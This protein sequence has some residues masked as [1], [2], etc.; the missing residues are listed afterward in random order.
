M[1]PRTDS[2]KKES[3]A[4]LLEDF[5]GGRCTAE[6]SVLEVLVTGFDGNR[7]SVA[8]GLKSDCEIPAEEFRDPNGEIKVKADDYVKVKIELLDDGRGRTRLSR[9]L[10]RRDQTWQN[11]LQCFASGEP[12]EGVIQERVKGGYSVHIDGLRCFLPGSLVDIFPLAEGQELIGSTERFLVERLKES[13]RSAILNRKILREREL[14]GNDMDC[15]TFAE[16][17]VVSGEVMA[18]AEYPENTAFVKIAE[19]VHG[20]LHRSDLSW[21]RVN[22][23]A[24]MIAV[25]DKF[26]VKVLKIDHEKKRI[27]VGVKDLHPDPYE[28]LE[29]R[30][31]KGTRLFGKV[32]AIKNYGAFVEIEK[33][34]EGLVHISEM[35]W[36]SNKVM[37]DQV[38]SIG[39]EIEVMMLGIDLQQRRISLGIKQ[40]KPNPWEEFNVA[41]R[42]GTKLIGTVQGITDFGMFVDLVDGLTGLVRMVDISNTKSGS[43]AILDYEEGQKVEVV[44]LN[45]EVKR[46]RIS[47]GIKQLANSSFDLYIK[48]HPPRTVV[49]GEVIKIGERSAILQL[50]DNVIG[51]LPIKEISEEHTASISEVMKTGDKIEVLILTADLSKRTM[52]LSIKARFRAEEVAAVSEYKK[53]EAIHAHTSDTS[54]GALLKDT[55]AQASE[56]ESTPER[57]EALTAG[58]SELAATSEEQAGQRQAASGAVAAPDQERVEDPKEISEIS[59]TVVRKGEPAPAGAADAVAT[60]E[61]GQ[62]H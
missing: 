38:L 4:Q 49:T 26:E 30:C 47:L 58:P 1:Q 52:L 55:L 8:A 43:E 45:V 27:K 15:V 12:I 24:D 59:E 23:L 31:P 35:D 22:Q 25:G 53:S 51:I 19:K 44:L 42:K 9:L 50:E 60:P 11:I 46:E 29:K 3:F 32:V 40:C 54:F 62:D 48:D 2:D 28:E 57:K 37:A 18:I 34:I 56:D 61:V 14:V 6:G 17:D 7:V 36:R 41:Y 13:Y 5:E 21:V 10:Y 20:R 39:D 33:G 16:G